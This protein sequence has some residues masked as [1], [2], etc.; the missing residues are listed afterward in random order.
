[1]SEIVAMVAAIFATDQMSP[2]L[3]QQIKDVFGEDSDPIEV[4]EARALKLLVELNPIVWE[5]DA[6]TF[7]FS[8]VGGAAE[9]ILGYPAGRWIEET[10][11]WADTVVHPEDRMGAISYCALATGQCADHDFQYRAIAANGSV[12][13]LHDIVKVIL[14]SRGIPVR[15]RGIMFQF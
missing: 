6:Q 10:T 9:A 1:M 3:A 8:F 12:V 2:A 15:L 14:G 5:G 11:F 7:H 13:Q 4:V